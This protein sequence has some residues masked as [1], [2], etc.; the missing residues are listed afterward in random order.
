MRDGVALALKSG[1]LT[2]VNLDWANQTLEQY[3]DSL[4]RRPAVAVNFVQFPFADADRTNL[5]AAYEQVKLDGGMLLLTLEPRQGL[6][7]VT[8]EA[9]DQLA[10]TLNGYN[11]AGVPVIVRFAHEMNGSWYGWG[12]QPA[13]YK[14]AFRRVAESIHRLAP[15]SAT[16]WAPNYGGG[17]PF[18]GG[19]HQAPAGSP[20]ARRRRNWT[21]ITTAPSPVRTIPTS[22]TTRVTM[23]W[24]GWACPCTTGEPRIRGAPTWCRSPES[25]SSSSPGAEMINWFE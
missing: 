12:Q 14:A 4:G 17:Y 19:Q 25:S 3:S 11:K 5:E 22:R 16:M 15:G 10:E 18:T 24:T 21:P 20:A 8:E 23:P 7:A 2:A 1:I 13:E 6:A 9:T